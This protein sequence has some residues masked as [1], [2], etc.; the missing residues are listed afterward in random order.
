MVSG[1]DD[2]EAIVLYS[3]KTRP[4]TIFMIRKP[5]LSHGLQS[6]FSAFYKSLGIF[7]K[8]LRSTE[9]LKEQQKIIPH[10]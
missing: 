4:T 3:V 5:R 7:P 6:H 8:D 2:F 10:F 9:T 1:G